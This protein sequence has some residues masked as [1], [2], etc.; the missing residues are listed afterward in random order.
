M[1]KRNR[2][3]LPW[4]LVSF[5]L[6][7]NGC[8]DDKEEN[9]TP[10][11]QTPPDDKTPESIITEPDDE[12]A[13][14]FDQNAIRTYEIQ[15]SEENLAFLDADP[16][17]EEYVDGSI[18]IDGVTYSDVGIRYKGGDGSWRVC[19]ESSATGVLDPDNPVEMDGK[20]L[21]HKLSI[22]VKF[23]WTDPEG[24]FKGL[25]KLQF[26][27]MIVDNTLLRERLGY[28]IYREMGVLAPRTAH[29]RVTVNG[30]LL[31]LFVLV[32]HIDGSFTRSHFKEGGRGNLYKEV[33][34]Q[35]SD[36][37]R[38][39]TGLRTNEDEDPSFDKMITLAK[40]LGEA[41]KT[42]TAHE[43]VEQW[44]DV[45]HTMR[46][47]VTEWGIGDDDGIYL[48]FCWEWDDPTTDDCT[49]H[50]FYFYEEQ[51][52]N[53]VWLLPWDLDYAFRGQGNLLPPLIKAWD[54]IVLCEIDRSTGIFG[55]IAPTCDPLLKGM[56]QY[57]EKYVRILE[58]LLNGPFQEE[59]IAQKIDA[60][61]A[62]VRPIVQEE[63]DEWGDEALSMVEWEYGIEALK[64][65][66][67]MLRKRN[68]EDL[69]ERKERLGMK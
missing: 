11:D 68:T 1:I 9:T 13:Y 61:I 45:N 18:I 27:A 39:L 44:M 4:L 65:N 23:N 34:P 47:I 69:A 62:Q 57:Q 15:L 22:K 49:N 25:R 60:W 50:N 67:D 63:I 64:R 43:V 7:F 17:L 30:R 56:I 21:C 46:H 2:Y 52:A 37:E 19:V 40:E 3:G 53:R 55:R 20:K 38:Y 59:A 48:W 36:T 6:L 16:A 24:R 14:L 28:S 66:I 12:A 54:D 42:D 10:V 33:W 26:H 29:A 51:E 41:N 58:E 35:W 8:G 31:G 32:E 5:S